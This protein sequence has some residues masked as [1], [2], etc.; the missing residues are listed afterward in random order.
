MFKKEKIMTLQVLATL[1]AISALIASVAGIV[2]PNIYKPIVADGEMPFVFAQD[3]ISFIAAIVL[4]FITLFV[5]KESMKLDIIRLGLVGYLFYVYGQYVMGTVYNYYYFL[6]LFVFSLS[7]FYLINAF[8]GIE[9][10]RL[11]FIIPKSLRIIIALYCA[12]IPV[13]FTPQWIIELFHHIQNGSR[14]GA[15]GLTFN[16]YVYILDLCFILPVCVMAS[17]FLFQKKNLGLL[18]GGLLSIFGF[19]LMLWVALG[20]FCQPLFH[21]KIDISGTVQFSIITFVFLVLSIFYFIYAEVIKT[22]ARP[23]A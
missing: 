6:Y 3:L 2:F 23:S 13:F 19:A 9:H 15:I 7:I 11:E 18:L 21:L 12:A 5:K 10:E 1:I 22:D 17:V 16:Y 14:P 8:A 20:F 4:L